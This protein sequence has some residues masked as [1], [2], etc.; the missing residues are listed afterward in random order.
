MRRSFLTVLIV[1]GAAVAGLCPAVAA[2]P[3]SATDAPSI[4][5]VVQ[6]QLDAFAADDAALAFSYAAPALREV[7][8]SPERFIAMVRAQYPVV[9]RPAAVSFWV[10]E[11]SGAEVVQRV[12]FTDV[13]GILWLAT[14]RLQR[15]PDN[16]WRISGCELAPS[17][18]RTT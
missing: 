6:A 11:G 18:A 8:G 7:F 15:Q 1:A 17:H 4:R 2:D 14:Y 9:Y 13:A 3:L 5:A 16:N 10:P 12:H